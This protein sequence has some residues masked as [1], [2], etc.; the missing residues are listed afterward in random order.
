MPL[1]YEHPLLVVTL[2]VQ[3]QLP[4]A[5]NGPVPQVTVATHDE[6]RRRLAHHAHHL[7][8]QHQLGVRRHGLGLA[9]PVAAVAAHLAVDGRRVAADRRRLL[10]HLARLRL[11]RAVE[12]ACPVAAGHAVCLRSE[13]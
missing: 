12:G 13:S 3:V 11:R 7:A 1:A 4:G 6:R 2:L 10:L 9:Q 5:V 8:E